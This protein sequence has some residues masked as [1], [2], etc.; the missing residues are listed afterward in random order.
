MR[1]RVLFVSVAV[2]AVVVLAFAGC[3]MFG[4]VGEDEA[5]TGIDEETQLDD[6][7]TTF[8]GSLEDYQSLSLKKSIAQEKDIKGIFDDVKIILFKNPN[9]DLMKNRLEYE[10]VSI[11]TDG[12]FSFDV[13]D[14]DTFMAFLIDQTQEYLKSVGLIGISTSSGEY[15]E[16]I[17]TGCLEGD[18][19]LG[20]ISESQ[21]ARLLNSENNID[22]IGAEITNRELVDYLA[23]NDNSLR[24][25]E[26][27]INSDFK[28][29]TFPTYNFMSGEKKQMTVWDETILDNISYQ[30]F[31]LGFISFKDGID[32]GDDSS[33]VPPYDIS[34]RSGTLFTNSDKILLNINR[35]FSMLDFDVIDQWLVYYGT[36]GGPSLFTGVPKDGYWNFID[37]NGT[38]VGKYNYL[39]AYPVEENDTS[40]I[41][42]LIPLFKANIK[43]GTT[44]IIE[45][46]QVRWYKISSGTYERV[47]PSMI[48]NIYDSWS[49][50]LRDYDEGVEG[51]EQKEITTF[52]DEEIFLEK[53]WHLT[54]IA[55]KYYADGINIG[56][57]GKGY[58]TFFEYRDE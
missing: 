20:T 28:M 54:D 10:E 11:Q 22:N 4:N 3:G 25:L 26:N 58:H 56:I 15:W 1:K 13:D 51:V 27:Y 41:T 33:V 37:E 17:D 36:S 38:T 45:S 49:F 48:E 7:V 52:S 57:F 21:T 30:G 9:S 42:T 53:E 55:Q 16:Y 43:S 47:D 5:D 2:I 6:A 40:H 8:S 32:H 24:V 31:Q 39:L 18:V 14:G 12:S 46:L 44:D 35:D 50:S 19:N 34:T 29:I 23:V